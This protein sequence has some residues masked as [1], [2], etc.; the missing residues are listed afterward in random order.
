MIVFRGDRVQFVRARERERWLTGLHSFDRS[1][2]F[3]GLYKG[4]FLYVS[5][6]KRGKRREGVSYR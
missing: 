6:C 3:C 4:L 1:W 2:I 5:F